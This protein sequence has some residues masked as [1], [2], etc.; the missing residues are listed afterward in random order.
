MASSKHYK[1]GVGNYYFS[2]KTGIQN[3]VISRTTKQ[4]AVNSYLSYKKVGKDAEWLGCWDG[5]KFKENSAPTA[6][7]LK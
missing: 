3:I 2:I 5:K 4:E 7:D 6:K 1:M